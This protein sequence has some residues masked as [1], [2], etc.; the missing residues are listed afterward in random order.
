MSFSW[1]PVNGKALDTLCYIISY[2]YYYIYFIM[3]YEHTCYAQLLYVPMYALTNKTSLS[4][5]LRGLPSHPHILS[6]AP[7]KGTD[8]EIFGSDKI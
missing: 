4:L 8:F 3:Y 6:V 2:S 1:F 5:S 7:L